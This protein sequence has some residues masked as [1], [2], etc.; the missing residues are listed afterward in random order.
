MRGGSDEPI[1]LNGSS[2]RKGWFGSMQRTKLSTI[3]LIA[4]FASGFDLPS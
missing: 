4:D 3:R 1:R 2:W